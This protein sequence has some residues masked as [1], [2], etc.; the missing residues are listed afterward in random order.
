[1]GEHNVGYHSTTTVRM[2]SIFLLAVTVPSGSQGLIADPAKCRLLSVDAKR[3]LVRELS[4]CPDKALE[5]LHEWSRCDI[6]QIFC[7]EFCE[8]R[9]YE[10]MSK[11]L[12][13]N[14]LFNAV[15]GKSH[16]HGKCMKRSGP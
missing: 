14:Y 9:K 10:V 5:L 16:G 11:Q 15:N 4:K 3:E 13:L 2:F 12:I 6:V 8:G 1:M 7:S